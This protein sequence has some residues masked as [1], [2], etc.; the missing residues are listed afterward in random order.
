MFYEQIMIFGPN[1]QK[2]PKKEGTPLVTPYKISTLPKSVGIEPYRSVI[3]SRA[4]EGFFGGPG[5]LGSASQLDFWAPGA[6]NG[7]IEEGRKSCFFGGDIL[8]G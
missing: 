5:T 2:E 1:G 3:V 4:Q 8:I 6:E 7:E